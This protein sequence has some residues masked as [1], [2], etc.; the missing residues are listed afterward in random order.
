MRA[1]NASLQN[2]AAGGV[3]LCRMANSCLM[4][5]VLVRLCI[6]GLLADE[7]QQILHGVCQLQ[8]HVLNVGESKTRFYRRTDCLQ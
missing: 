1:V 3:A 5:K 7:E 2:L 8:L 4:K 6:C